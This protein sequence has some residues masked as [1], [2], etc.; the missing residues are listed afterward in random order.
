MYDYQE[1]SVFVLAARDKY[2]V[3]EIF[4][5][6]T[7]LCLLLINISTICRSRPPVPGV[8]KWSW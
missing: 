5:M 4:H 6:G 2:L 7:K 1:S 8:R 3:S